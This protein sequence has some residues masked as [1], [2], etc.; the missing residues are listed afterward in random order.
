MDTLVL[1]CGFLG[2]WLLVAGPVYQAALELQEQELERD[3]IARASATTEHGPPVSPWWWLLPPVHWWLQRR[4][5]RAFHKAVYHVLP[6]RQR[7]QLVRYFNKAT[8][9][10]Y[11]ALGGFLV[12]V[13]ATSA[14]AE[15]AGWPDRVDV[16]LIVGMS[17][18]SVYHTAARMSH[19]E[20]VLD[21]GSGPEPPEVGRRGPQ[22]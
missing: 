13:E 8:G 12:A 2:S 5:N 21:S 6:A 20:R 16:P 17:L 18:L 9:W 11:V 1:W 3:E 22:A 14:L 15:H 4:R 10:L 7:E 19:A